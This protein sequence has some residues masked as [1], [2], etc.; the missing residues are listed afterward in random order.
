MVRL[1]QHMVFICLQ[2]LENG[3]SNTSIQCHFAHF[4]ILIIIIRILIYFFFA[5]K[6]MI[7]SLSTAYTRLF[8]FPSANCRSR[9]RRS[10]HERPLRREGGHCRQLCVLLRAHGQ[11]LL[12]NER[13]HR[14]VHQGQAGHLGLPLQS[15]LL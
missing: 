10:L 2:S 14:Q 5:C 7:L 4:L 13:P 3:F 9:R 12:P 11:G 1:V 6:E 15:I 8:V